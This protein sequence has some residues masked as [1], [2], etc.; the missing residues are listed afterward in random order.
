MEKFGLMEFVEQ[1]LGNN[2][3]KDGEQDKANQTG[4][5]Q[6]TDKA[7]PSHNP[8]AILKIMS[9]HDKIRN[10]IDNKKNGE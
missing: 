10:S 4:N 9:T 3:K 2:T 1:I 6:Q 7:T 5:N 8:D